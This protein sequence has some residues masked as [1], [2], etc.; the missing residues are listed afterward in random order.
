SP[1]TGISSRSPCWSRSLSSPGS[2]CW[3]TVA[4]H[5]PGALVPGRRPGGVGRAFP[6]FVHHGRG[7]VCTR[8]PGRAAGACTPCIVRIHGGRAGLDRLAGLAWLEAAPRRAGIAAARRPE[9][10]GPRQVR[11]L[12]NGAALWL[13]VR[14]C[15]LRGVVG[16]ADRELPLMLHAAHRRWLLAAGLL[17]LG[18]AWLGPLPAWSRHWFSAHM[19]MHMAVVAV[20][21]PLVASSIAG[22]RADPARHW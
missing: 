9:R 15:R 12:R 1:C 11:R 8:C 20:A 2:R 22:T 10:S 19:L 21:A 14:R 5:E 6:G 4:G 17:V 7:V 16:G 18:A 3:R 13:V